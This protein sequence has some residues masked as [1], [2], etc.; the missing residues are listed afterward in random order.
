M[1]ETLTK[2][3]PEDDELLRHPPEK[4]QLLP[5]NQDKTPL[6]EFNMAISK[7]QNWGRELYGT[8]GS[9][10]S[11]ALKPHPRDR[12]ILINKVIRDITST[13]GYIP[14]KP[15]DRVLPSKLP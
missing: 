10:S 5:H 8:G 14:K 12:Y 15:R 11:K 2:T 3:I 9:Q 1:F 6:D 4:K 7:N 13:I